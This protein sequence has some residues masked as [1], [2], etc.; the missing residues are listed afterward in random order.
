M[1]RDLTLSR[2]C[3]ISREDVSSPGLSHM[4]NTMDGDRGGGLV[5]SRREAT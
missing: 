2:G 1:L 5:R 4:D 3:H